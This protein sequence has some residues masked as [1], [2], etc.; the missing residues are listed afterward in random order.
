[1]RRQKTDFGAGRSDGKIENPLKEGA[2]TS[3][4]EIFLS[5][6]MPTKTCIG[7]TWYASATLFQLGLW[8]GL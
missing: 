6:G 1:M 4:S 7:K 3:A 5:S 8:L 2:P